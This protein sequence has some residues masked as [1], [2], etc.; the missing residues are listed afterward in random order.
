MGSCVSC[1][2]P[3]EDHEQVEA[4][5]PPPSPDLQEEID[6]LKEELQEVNFFL[7]YKLITKDAEMA[8]REMESKMREAKLIQEIDFWRGRKYY[9]D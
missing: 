4:P 9:Q 7:N 2:K 8:R 1:E 6:L 3:V 5:L